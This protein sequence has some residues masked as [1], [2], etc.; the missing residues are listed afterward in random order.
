MN[1][2]FTLRDYWSIH[3]SFQHTL[4]GGRTPGGAQALDDKDLGISVSNYRNLWHLEPVGFHEV[5]PYKLVCPIYTCISR[6]FFGCVSCC[7]RS[8]TNPGKGRWSFLTN[9]LKQ[10]ETIDI[11]YLKPSSQVCRE[12]TKS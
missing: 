5:C 8:T 3:F 6:G 10:L 7:Y 4:T 1:F 2:F 9:Q 12:A 11:F